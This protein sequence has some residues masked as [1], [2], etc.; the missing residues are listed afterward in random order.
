MTNLKKLPD[1]EIVF[2]QS[3]D[4]TIHLEVL[5]AGENVRLSQRALAT[6]FDCSVD[7]IALHLKNLYQDKEID[8]IAT[9]EDSSIVQIE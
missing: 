2:F 8:E 5:F 4:G 7:N 6:L 1:N 9:S 3:K